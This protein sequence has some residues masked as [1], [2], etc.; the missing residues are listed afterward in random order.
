[1]SVPPLSAGHFDPIAPVPLAAPA[2][3]KVSVCTITYNHER[4]LEQAV[5]S[6]AM[7]QTTFPFEMVIGE[8]CS[9]DRTREV[10][11]AC[12][13]KYPRLVR[14]ITREK[15]VGAQANFVENLR[16]CGGSYVALLEG[17]DYWTDPYKLQRQAD[18]LDV[19]PEYVGHSYNA[20]IFEERS[21][22]SRSFGLADARAYG[23]GDLL[24]LN[25]MPTCGVMFRNGLLPDLPDWFNS[26]SAGDW[27]LHILHARFGDFWYDPT[28]M[29]RYRVHPEGTWSA[30]TA[31]ARLL[32]DL[33]VYELLR[34]TLDRRWDGPLREFISRKH[35]ELALRAEN[36]GDLVAAR[37]HLKQCVRAYPLRALVQRPSRVSAA[38]R[39]Y[40][41][42]FHSAA[43]HLFSR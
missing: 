19:H 37:K 38:F 11:Q 43:K 5:E 13:R 28:I 23:L 21:G 25:Y 7:Q 8:D 41:P 14:L 35:F 9:T 27:T 31:A 1:M 18:F 33:H 4:Y 24:H 29:G 2:R 34:G 10:A 22:D 15:N 20:M 30:K 36:D 17:D 3:P 12:L 16:A 39:L 26:I 6:V 42:N 32:S 40:T